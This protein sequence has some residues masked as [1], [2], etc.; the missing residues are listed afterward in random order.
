MAVE[1]RTVYSFD[2]EKFFALEFEQQSGPDG[3]FPE[4]FP[5]QTDVPTPSYTSKEIPKWTGKEWTIVP[6]YMFTSLWH[7]DT[8]PVSVDIIKKGMSLEDLKAIDIPP[9][10]D[11]YF[12]D[13]TEWVI[14]EE[15]KRE[16]DIATWA[17]NRDAAIDQVS[18]PILIS[19]DQASVGIDPMLSKEALDEAIKYRIRLY[20]LSELEEIPPCP[21]SL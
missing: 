3:V 14:D 19:Q 20:A 15:K 5:S 21:I 12:W 16:H 13:G 7:F 18:T 10:D 2:K 6:N 8:S 4:L 9:P 1:I 11:F 17:S